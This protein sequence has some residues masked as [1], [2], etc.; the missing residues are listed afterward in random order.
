MRLGIKFTPPNTTRA[1]SQLK[2]ARHLI[3]PM[4]GACPEARL[5]SGHPEAFPGVD[6]QR[7]V[8][9]ASNATSPVRR[10]LQ[11]VSEHIH[12]ERQAFGAR[13]DVLYHP[14]TQEH[15]FKTFRVPQVV[16]VHDMLPVRFAEAFPLTSKQWRW[17]ILPSLKNVSHIICP[18]LST[19][20]ELIDVTGISEDRVHVVHHG[21]VPRKI[22][23]AQESA[24]VRVPY[25]LY[26]ASGAYP[27]KNIIR[28]TKAFASIARQVP[29]ELLVVGAIHPRFK[30][31]IGEC[32]AISDRFHFLHD[33]SDSELDLLYR[34]ADAFVYPSLYEGFGLPPLEA[35]MCEIPVAAST[36]TSIPEVCGAAALYFDPMSVEGI[37]ESMLRVIG[38][39]PLRRDLVARGKARLAELSWDK[40]VAQTLSVCSKALA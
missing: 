12:F 8:R 21:F 17:Y 32:E 13:V 33:V 14:Y 36:A 38:D 20:R 3:V 7:I 31:I 10:A 9:V 23:T 26:V 4:M 37:A 11:I 6:P 34:A 29:H 1:G 28:L 35:M 19:K 18:S 15:L 22:N 30:A 24:H 39:A 5:F 27:H 25:L 40:A 16:T 2:I